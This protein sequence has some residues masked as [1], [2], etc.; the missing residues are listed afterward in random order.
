MDSKW[1]IWQVDGVAADVVENHET[2]VFLAYIYINHR[3]RL[4]GVYH[5]WHVLVWNQIAYDN[6]Y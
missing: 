1:N 4:Y 2:M 5:I 6:D 3:H